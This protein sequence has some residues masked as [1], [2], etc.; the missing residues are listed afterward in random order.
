MQLT[1]LQEMAYD[2]KPHMRMTA[3]Q[4][5][6]CDQKPPHMQL[7]ALQEMACDLKPHVRMTALQEATCDQKPLQL[8]A[9]QEMACYQKPLPPT[10]L[11]DMACDQGLTAALPAALQRKV[12]QKPPVPLPQMTALKNNVLADSVAGDCERLRGC[13]GQHCGVA[14]ATASPRAGGAGPVREAA[15]DGVASAPAAGEPLGSRAPEGQARGSREAAAAPFSQPEA[16]CGNALSP[17]ATVALAPAAAPTP[18][19]PCSG[20]TRTL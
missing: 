10:A 6:A 16:L 8:T 19:R 5:M 1:A 13:Q 11:Q 9:L 4:E 3:L 15:A 20:H 7:A 2:L 18:S 12:Y 17:G 14:G